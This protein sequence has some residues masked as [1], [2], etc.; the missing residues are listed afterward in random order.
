MRYVYPKLK[1]IDSRDGEC[2]CTVKL[3]ENAAKL[4][5]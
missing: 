5:K 1:R 2:K 3:S 4:A